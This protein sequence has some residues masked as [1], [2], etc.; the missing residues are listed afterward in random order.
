MK[1]NEEQTEI[2]AKTHFPKAPSQPAEHLCVLFSAKNDAIG[3]QHPPVRFPQVS[4]L[5][6]PSFTTVG[7]RKE[8]RKKGG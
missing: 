5:L 3:C 4:L 6:Q 1:C 2:K 8:R 7:K